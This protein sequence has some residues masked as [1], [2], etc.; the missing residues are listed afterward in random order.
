MAK[1]ELGPINPELSAADQAVAMRTKLNVLRRDQGEEPVRKEDLDAFLEAFP[2]VQEDLRTLDFNQNTPTVHGAYALLNDFLADRP[3][4]PERDP[5]VWDR[6]QALASGLVTASGDP[7][8]P[9]YFPIEGYRWADDS[10]GSENW[11]VV[12]IPAAEKQA[13]APSL[14]GD[15]KKLGYSEENW[16]P[17][18]EKVVREEGLAG[19]AWYE[20]IDSSDDKLY[21]E[22][23]LKIAPNF[24]DIN[25]LSKGQLQFYDDEIAWLKD[26]ATVENLAAVAVL[27]PEKPAV[28]KEAL[29][30][31]GLALQ[32]EFTAL[33]YNEQN[34]K[35]FLNMVSKDNGLY[36]SNDQYHAEKLLSAAATF[37][38]FI[39]LSEG[40]LQ[41]YS[42]QLD[43]LREPSTTERLGSLTLIAP[44]AAPAAPAAPAEP[45]PRNA[46]SEEVVA[47]RR[48]P[49]VSASAPQGTAPTAPSAT[50]S[51]TSGA[52]SGSAAPAPSAA[53]A[54]TVAAAPAAPE[55][56]VEDPK[57][58]AEW[59][60]DRKS[61][62]FTAPAGS[63]ADK[64]LRIEELLTTND[65][66]KLVL[67]SSNPNLKG[68]FTFQEGPQGP[69][70]Y[71]TEKQRLV[72]RSGDELTKKVEEA[73]KVASAEPT[74]AE[75]EPT[76]IPFDRAPKGTAD[77]KTLKVAF[78]QLS[79]DETYVANAREEIARLEAKK[80][81][82]LSNDK[83]I[84]GE[85]A[86]IEASIA[87]AEDQIA[88]NRAT[89][90]E[91][92]GTDAY[93]AV[94]TEEEPE[95]IAQLG[96]GMEGMD[97]ALTRAVAKADAKPKEATPVTAVSETA[98]AANSG[99][100]THDEI[101]SFLTEDE[102][103]TKATQLKDASDTP[104][105]DA[106]LTESIR[107]LTA[108]ISAQQA[109]PA[110]ASVMYEVFG[111]RDARVALNLP[112][113]T[114]TLLSPIT[115]A[116]ETAVAEATTDAPPPASIP[117]VGASADADVGEPAPAPADTEDGAADGN[118]GES[119]DPTENAGA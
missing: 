60:A 8:D 64:K 77:V 70:W 40:E 16:R 63:E 73:P 97:P 18:L 58:Y 81:K 85:I 46:P 102:L 88:T 69:S 44:K 24:S 56:A 22:Q 67:T 95:R 98:V 116:K 57:K 12:K 53:P 14:K 20:G 34:W 119:P 78:D 26:Q 27:P 84:N 13:E 42:E 115:D 10:E 55:A 71:N 17:F 47:V 3:Q 5:N 25:K 68:E 80:D 59:S 38:K 23:I 1:E 62:K 36:N 49:G 9:E 105:K 21:A 113:P 52:L 48:E 87:K 111:N 41:I 103:R 33:G 32:K 101:V 79:N 89:L 50:A 6:A 51:S 31:R 61:F 91:N 2:E 37:D 11:R 65:E 19:R 109:N 72:I 29:S 39:R 100:E 106:A 118:N 83:K 107:I 15:L 93:L 7:A 75:A 112:D 96:I 35:P 90:L 66:R 92:R 43:W 45:A 110:Y 74:A 54:A 114:P 108:E 30:E 104:V 28:N 94:M 4:A 117:S 76:V 86:T 99:V 82:W